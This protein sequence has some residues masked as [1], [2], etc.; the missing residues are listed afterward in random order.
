MTVYTNFFALISMTTLTLMSGDLMSVMWLATSNRNLQ[1]SL[2]AYTAV[3]Y[4]AISVY[5]MLVKRFGGIT[6]VLISTTR[7]AMSLVLS[8]LFFPKEFSWFYVSGA[9]LV[10]GGMITVDLNIQ[11]KKSEEK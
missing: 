7:K 10:L 8:L 3:S 1:F 5:M 11:I 4:I 6:A 9:T 2:M